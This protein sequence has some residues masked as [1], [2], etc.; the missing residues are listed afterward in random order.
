MRRYI[1]ILLMICA[2]PMVGLA[3]TDT[4]E[5][6]LS[7][8][9]KH[10]NAPNFQPTGVCKLMEY[11]ID[12]ENKTISINTNDVFGA[13]P[14]TDKI[15]KSIYASISNTLPDNYKSY[16]LMLSSEGRNIETLIPNPYRNKHDKTRMF[17]GKA[18][19][20]EPWV[21]NESKP[22]TFNS[23]LQNHHLA[24]CA[25][26][27]RYYSHS[28]NAWRWQRP[29]LFSTTEDLL[30][31][32]FVVPFLIPML[33]NA[34]AIV[35]SPRERSWQRSE[36]IVDNDAPAANGTYMEKQSKNP[37][38]QTQCPGWGCTKSVI[39]D[40]ENPFEM[41]TARIAKSI[42]NKSKASQIKWTPNIKTAGNYPVYISYA[43]A[44]DAI[45]DANYSVHHAGIVTNFKVNQRMGSGTWVYLGTFYFEKGESD[46]NCVVLSNFSTKNGVVTADA[47]RFGGGMGNISR[48]ENA[49]TGEPQLSRLPRYLEGARY[50]A[51]WYGMPNNVYS[52]YSGT[53]D[54][55]D[56]I[57]ARSYAVNYLAGGSVFLPNAEGKKVPFELSL[58]VHSDAG[59]KSH[60]IVGTMGI[61]T[62]N[63]LAGETQYQ[64]GVSR[65]ASFDF[66]SMLTDGIATEL[67]K[68]YRIQWARREVHDKNYSESNRP[69]I[70]SAILEMLSHQNFHDM[71]Y[72]HDPWFKFNL[73]RSAYKAILRFISFEHGKKFTVSP[74]A[75]DN[76][77]IEFTGTNEVTLKWNAVK[78]SLEPSADPIGF[79]VY[80]RMGNGDFD[81]GE[82]VKKNHFTQKLTPGIVYSFRVTAVNK[83]GESFPSEIL[84]ACRANTPS[85][86]LLVVNCFDRLSGPAVVENNDSVGFDINKDIG[87]PY[88]QTPEYSGEQKYFDI[89]RGG[90]DSETGL[91]KS[92]YELANTMIAG[93]TFD[94]VFEHGI[95]LS[96]RYSF[97]SCSR[98][99][100]ENGS[101]NLAKYPMVDLIFGLQKS[102][103]YDFRNF[104]TFNSALRSKV[105]AYLSNGG[106]LLSSGAYLGCDMKSTA[107]RTFL[108]QQLH[109]TYSGELRNKTN[110]SGAEEV[111]SVEQDLGKE[112]YAVQSMDCLRPLN[113]AQVAFKYSEGASAGV[114][115]QGTQYRCAT[116]G[117]PL[118]SIKDKATQKRV[119]LKLA[120]FLLAEK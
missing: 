52:S 110:I 107:E 57:N 112:T 21:F 66:A 24:I 70:P 6:I 71:V 75:P 69:A 94:Y 13:Q 117:F 111:F 115:Y 45:D 1:Y 114:L 119:I 4:L 63:G 93:N 51:Q 102:S 41:G 10:Y 50:S 78:D 29:Y 99:S 35:Y 74:L 47:V 79:I 22:Y 5:T 76:F 91:G 20:G 97:V 68:I 61:A 82:F 38:Q 34:G 77:R 118:E 53:D 23:G 92:G 37:W 44:T 109:C 81:N 28:E 89:N 17:N 49:E 42:S 106:A 46:R 90:D 87:V 72:A 100:V 7:D 56:D 103:H 19:N 27:G 39:Y 40:N 64:S 11:N 18:Y 104:K 120:K 15:V 80:T 25:S 113:G 67:S 33:E 105:N 8:Y 95:A 30:T 48:G 88:V 16:N 59:Y 2:M 85:R 14:F 26:H 73:A 36:I 96:S 55:K 9:F 58:A 83:G 43:Q 3:Q 12:E 54:Y 98:K 86:P 60:G 31:Q 116:L 84:A 101:V 32:T 108:S 65:K 62:T